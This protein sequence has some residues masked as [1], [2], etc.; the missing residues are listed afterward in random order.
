MAGVQRIVHVAS[1]PPGSALAQDIVAFV[2]EGRGVKAA[3]H[4]GQV[5]LEIRLVVDFGHEIGD[6]T[7]E[8]RKA[9]RTRVEELAGV[10]VSS[11]RVEV[12][13]VLTPT[14]PAGS[15]GTSAA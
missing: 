14:D 5:R 10:S 4:R 9:V 1:P 2:A 11:I 7:R 13:E 8:V 12:T 6:V 15:G 3:R